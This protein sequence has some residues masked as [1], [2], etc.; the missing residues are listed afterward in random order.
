MD[1]FTTKVRSKVMRSVRS[2]KNKSTELK[3]V[4]LFL[5][6]EIK[7]WRRNSPL[8]GSPDFVFP[9]KRVA[10]FTDGCFWHGHPCRNIKPQ[11]N[12]SYWQLKIKRNRRR[13]RYVSKELN[14]RGWQ[15]LRL[16]ECQLSKRPNAC[17]KKIC[18]VIKD[19]IN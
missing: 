1:V 3:L 9:Q 18:K 12:S 5:A 19:K 6:N 7:G 8:F 17:I 10:V 15:V 14:K 4:D 16:W 13:D 11:A 2:R